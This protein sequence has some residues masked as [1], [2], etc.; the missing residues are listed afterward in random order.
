[1][2]EFFIDIKSNINYYI[3]RGK[4]WLD[5]LRNMKNSDNLSKAL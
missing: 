4:I 5:E 2:Y 1:M 3:F